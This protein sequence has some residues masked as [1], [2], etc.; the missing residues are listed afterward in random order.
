MEDKLVEAEK[1][2]QNTG[3]KDSVKEGAKVAVSGDRNESEKA[4]HK[5]IEET[6]EFVRRS[7]GADR[8][9]E[10]KQAPKGYDKK[11][12]EER[13]TEQFLEMYNNKNDSKKG[14]AET[15]EL[16]E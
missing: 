13:K 1:D 10:G 15:K 11:R 12:D 7:T 6:Q 14:N 16:G 4:D 3:E 8:V 2:R 9:S 5:E